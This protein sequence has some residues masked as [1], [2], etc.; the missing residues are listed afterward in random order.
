MGSRIW[1]GDGLESVNFLLRIQ[2]LNN[3]FWG[4]G[5]GGGGWG[6]VGGGG[7]LE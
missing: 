4:R 3:F 7:G 2:M 1:G 5:G 6:A